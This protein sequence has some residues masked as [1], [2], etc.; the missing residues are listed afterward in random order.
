MT[1]QRTS[2][3]NAAMS[4]DELAPQQSEN[5]LDFREILAAAFRARY[6]ILGIMAACIIAGII[7]TLMTTRQYEGVATVEVRQEAAKVLGTEDDREPAQ[8]KLDIDRFLDTQ[9]GIVRSRMV[10]IAVADELGLFRN[11]FLEKMKAD[12]EIDQQVFLSPEQ[13]RREAV[14]QALTENL[15]VGYTGQTRILTIHFYS[16]DPALSAKVANSYASS[17]IRSNLRRKSESSSYALEF[18]Q[19]QL[20]EAQARLEES[21]QSLIEYGRRTQIVDASNAAGE[22]GQSQNQQP[23]SLITARLVQLNESYSAAVANRIAAEQR[24]RRIA[25]LPVM[26]IPEVLGN[27]AVQGLV[28]TRASLEAELREQ[29]KTKQDDYPTVV[30]L[31]ARLDEINRQTNVLA[32]SIRNSVESGYEVARNQESRLKSELETLKS[33]TLAEQGQSIQLSILR[34]EADT[35]RAQYEALLRRYNQLNAESGVQANNLAIVDR[36]VIEPKPSSPRISL[37][38]ALSILAGLVLSVL[39]LLAQVHL[40]DRIRTPNDVTER[41][42]LSFLGAI[43]VVDDVLEEMGDPKSE[44]GEAVNLVRTALSL[45]SEDGAPRTAMVTSVQPS[46]GKSN[47]VIAV[48]IGFS[49][50][51]KRVLLIDCDLRRPNIHRR[52]DLSNK[53]GVSSV[54][55]AQSDFASSIQHTRFERVDALTS[56]P[57]PPN[58]VD[59]FMGSHF[60]EMLEA[61]RERYD[62]VLLDAPPMLSLADSE[63]LATHIEQCIF[64]I[65][66]GRNSRK[67]VNQA[68]ERLER[69]GAQITGVVLTKYNPGEMGYGYNSHYAYQYRYGNTETPS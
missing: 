24:W 22:S 45:S 67:A 6:V 38:I 64:V 20:R 39:Y 56:G 13:A 34:R 65:E 21:E 49:R 3:F 51:G 5:V 42:R 27:Q 40:F 41:L 15:A 10:A 4:D 29:L 69:N 16:P 23:R 14:I 59:L 17:Y 35:N 1:M 44:V 61:A 60:D 12:D 8:S 11:D 46:E 63:L 28:E 52:L 58:P 54:L 47:S 48:A 18:L 32:G 7:I 68:T 53:A 57:I 9:V 50:I 62:I 33:E 25:K 26:S 31:R 37:N 66:S 43:P 55:S 19:R 36:A 30:Q 2:D